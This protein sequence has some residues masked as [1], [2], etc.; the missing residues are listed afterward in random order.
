[1]LSKCRCRWTE[2][3]LNIQNIKL[4][5]VLESRRSEAPAANR[6][7]GLTVEIWIIWI[8]H[9]RRV[10]CGDTGARGRDCCYQFKF[11][12]SLAGGWAGGGGTFYPAPSPAL[13]PL[14]PLF[15]RDCEAHTLY[16][17]ITQS[18]CYWHN[19]WVHMIAKQC[20]DN[21]GVSR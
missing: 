7:R 21:G 15:H 1:M 6:R 20:L 19:L 4:A 11:M 8:L 2:L 5:A 17:R 14:S 3:S 16:R 18:L 12:Q 10:G 13:P 9:E